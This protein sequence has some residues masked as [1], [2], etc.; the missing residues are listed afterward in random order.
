[1]CRIKIKNFGPIREGLVDN[2]GWIDVKKVTVLIGD[3][4][5]GKSTVAKLI[6]VFTWLEKNIVRN[7]ITTEHLNVEVLKNLCL[8]QEIVEYF[9]PNTFLKY[10][11]DAYEFEYDEKKKSFIVKINDNNYS[12]YV[13]PKIQYVSAARNLLTILYNISLQNIVD[14]NGNII[15]LSSN[16]PFMVISSHNYLLLL[17][18]GYISSFISCWQQPNSA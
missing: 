4:C 16:I 3:Q 9:T 5:S 12:N 8:Q 15:D 11:G 7:I 17:L 18:C 1:M 6:S 2:D 10:E 14:K 13:L